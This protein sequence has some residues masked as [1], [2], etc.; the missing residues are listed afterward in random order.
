MKY[1]ESKEDPPM[2]IVRTHQHDI[3]PA[4][5]QRARCP[6]TEF[7]RGTRQIKDSHSRKDKRQMAR[8]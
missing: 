1:V 6:K 7:Q 4:L 8:K 5:L 2:Q 3:H